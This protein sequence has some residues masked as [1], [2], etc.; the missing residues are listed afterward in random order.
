MSFRMDIKIWLATLS[1]SMIGGS[2][3][4]KALLFGMMVLVKL[5]SAVVIVHLIMLDLNFMGSIQ[6]MVQTLQFE[7][8][9][10]SKNG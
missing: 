2:Q 10:G 8:L 3:K 5:Q 9:R 7:Y 1:H 6:L 4:K